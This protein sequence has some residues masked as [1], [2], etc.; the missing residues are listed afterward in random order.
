MKETTES[1]VKRMGDIMTRCESRDFLE[2]IVG[3]VESAVDKFNEK[4]DEKGD[5]WKELPIAYLRE[6]LHKE[7][8]EFREAMSSGEYKKEMAEIVDII[9]VSTMLHGRYDEQISSGLYHHH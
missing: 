3:V 2:A 8:D 1:L 6:L 4:F 9:N 7:F 5:S